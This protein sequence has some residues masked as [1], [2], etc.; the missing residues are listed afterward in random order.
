MTRGKL[1]LFTDNEVFSSVEFNGDMYWDGFGK[2]AA[3][4]LQK[5]D[6]VNKFIKQVHKFDKKYF[7]YYHECGR[8]ALVSPIYPDWGPDHIIDLRTDYYKIWFSDYLYIKN[9]ASYTLTFLGNETCWDNE[10]QH[11]NNNDVIYKLAPGDIGIFNFTEAAA[12]TRDCKK[13][14][15][16]Q[17]YPEMAQGH[18]GDEDN[19]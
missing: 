10:Q 5:S 19:A 17:K 13:Q 2:D 11:F 4:A 12:D 15:K 14:N 8:D 18:D 3:K 16:L 9:L 7:G 6:S 1:V